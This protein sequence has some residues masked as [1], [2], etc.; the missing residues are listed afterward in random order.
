MREPLFVSI[1][2]ACCWNF[3][4]FLFRVGQIWFHLITL[5]AIQ[6][7]RSKRPPNYTWSAH[8]QT[9]WFRYR[10]DLLLSEPLSSNFIST[11]HSFESPDYVLQDHVTLYGITEH[12]AI[13]VECERDFD[14]LH[15]DAGSFLRVA[16]FHNAK[17]VITMPMTSFHKLARQVGD[18]KG[19][20]IFVSN[21]NRCGS[22]LLCQMFEEC[23]RVLVFSNPSALNSIYKGVAASSQ[24]ELREVVR[25]TVRLLCKPI[26]RAIQV[27]VVKPT[28]Q[29]VVAVPDFARVFPKSKQLFMYREGV[30]VAKSVFKAGLT[31]P[32]MHIVFLVTPFSGRLTQE[33]VVAMGLNASLMKHRCADGLVYGFFVW[34]SVIAK[35]REFVRQGIDIVGVK[36]EDLVE[37]PLEATRIVFE[38]CGIPVEWAEK[39]INALNK[40]AQRLSPLSRK[41]LDK[42][43]LNMEV[44]P[45]RRKEID[46]ICDHFRLPRIPK[47]VRT[48]ANHHPATS[49][50]DYESCAQVLPLNN[51]CS[52]SI[53]IYG[54]PYA[55]FCFLT[56]IIILNSN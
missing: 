7:W 51:L 39:A 14:V 17:R 32:L 35:Y 41:N 21:T 15:S 47:R 1:S 37:R 2:K 10:F 12:E 28:A 36:Y 55:Y 44:T 19:T 33:G 4:R 48:R 52:L 45:T 29:T 9:V 8:V 26:R 42:V 30:S 18:P 49:P 56:C 13:F 31:L 27:Y 50:T 5:R 25:S 53:Y 20:L 3:C 46:A 54:K 23:D 22:T 34:A 38:Y 6:I 43:K 40:D 24:T 11:H 16:Q